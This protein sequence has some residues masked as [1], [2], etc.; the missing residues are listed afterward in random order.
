MPKYNVLLHV[1]ESEN[2]KRIFI[3]RNSVL[4]VKLTCSQCREETPKYVFVDPNEEIA[5]DGGGMRNCIVKC[6]S[7]KANTIS[8][9]IIKSAGKNEWRPEN[10]E[11]DNVLVTL[12]VRGGDPSEFWVNDIWTVEAATEGD[13]EGKLFEG[14]DL[15]EDWCEYDEDS[16]QALSLLGVSASFTKIK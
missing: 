1:E 6:P 13:G 8:V 11:A 10:N 3:T 14:V 15:S 9:S 7:C 5:G 2:V 4:S 16:Q 12:E